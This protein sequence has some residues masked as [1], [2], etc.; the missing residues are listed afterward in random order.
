MDELL[1]EA[2]H[3]TSRL[4][5]IQRQVSNETKMARQHWARSVKKGL[6]AELNFASGCAELLEVRKQ[7]W[8]QSWV[9]LG[10]V[11]VR[12]LCA[13]FARLGDHHARQGEIESLGATSPWMV[14][15]G[16]RTAVGCGCIRPIFVFG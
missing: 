14:M 2:C 10:M 8:E 13:V 16:V 9:G 7:S 1:C 5:E 3:L 4:F 6:Q 12:S 15:F 11:R